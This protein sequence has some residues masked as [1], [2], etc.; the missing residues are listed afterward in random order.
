MKKNHGKDEERARD[1][2]YALWVPD[3]FMMRV[4]SDGN[5]SLM[6]PNE[7]PG[8]TDVWGDEFNKL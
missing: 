3:L 7:S 1:L 4:E 8:L 6:C 2:F 5:W